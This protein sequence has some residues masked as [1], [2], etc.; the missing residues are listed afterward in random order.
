MADLKL[1][2]ITGR[3]V[4][5]R[6]NIDLTELHQLIF[7]NQLPVFNREYK[8]EKEIYYERGEDQNSFLPDIDFNILY[9]FN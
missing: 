5:E 3:R 6:W 1:G 8:Q 2:W 7:D 9:E 4:V